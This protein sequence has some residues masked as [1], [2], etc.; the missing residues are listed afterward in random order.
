MHCFGIRH[1][2]ASVVT[3]VADHVA[4]QFAR[5]VACIILVCLTH[6]DN[7]SL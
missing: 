6:S 3:T 1:T 5:N 2:A 7:S 4:P